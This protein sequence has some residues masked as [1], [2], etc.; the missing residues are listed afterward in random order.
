M[1][2]GN[3]IST[4]TIYNKTGEFR[5]DQ[6]IYIM[7]HLIDYTNSY[8]DIWK[9]HIN[10]ERIVFSVIIREKMTC[11]RMSCLEEKHG[12]SDRLRSL[13]TLMAEDHIR[14]RWNLGV[15]AKRLF[16]KMKSVLIYFIRWIIKLE[17]W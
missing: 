15:R 16:N 9:F 13:A 7:Q 3:Q 1:S 14:C 6:N 17:K 10:Y 5:A 11:Y 4:E 12:Q 2:T 8:V